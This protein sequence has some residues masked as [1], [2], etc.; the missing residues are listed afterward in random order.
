MGE[1]KKVVMSEWF[2]HLTFNVVLT[3]IAGKRYFN[4]V[5]HGGEEARSAIAAIKKFMSLSGALWHQIKLVEE[6][7]GRLNGEAS[8]RLDLIDVMLTMLKG[9]SCFATHARLLSRQQYVPH[10]AMEDCMLVAITFPK[11]PAC[12]S[13]HGSCTEILLFGLTLKS[14]SQRDF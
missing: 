11:A 14:F 5:V 6:H 1:F 10:E 9:A 13:M 3:M 4:D 12:W 8:S 2:E 7:R